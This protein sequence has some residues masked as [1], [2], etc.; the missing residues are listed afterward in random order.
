MEVLVFLVPLALALGTIG[1][2]GF[3]WSLK[4][5]QYDDLEGAGWRATPMTSRPPLNQHG[6]FDR[7]WTSLGRHR[8]SVDDQRVRSARCDP[9]HPPGDERRPNKDRPKAAPVSNS[10][11]WRFR[12]SRN[13]R[14]AKR[15]SFALSQ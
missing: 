2:T 12:S 3:L 5:G 13:P 6:T 7:D 11:R 4:N 15:A 9:L 8:A 14:I 10:R 1:L